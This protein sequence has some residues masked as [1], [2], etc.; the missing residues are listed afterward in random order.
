MWPE[1]SS[2]SPRSQARISC[3][4]AITMMASF[5]PAHAAGM[6]GFTT[7]KVIQFGIGYCPSLRCDK[8]APFLCNNGQYPMASSGCS[9][10]VIRQYLEDQ[11]QTEL[12]HPRPAFAQPRVARGYVW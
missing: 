10:F 11:L 6:A 3:G 8:T 9:A 4:G 2:I 5:A 12:N 1:A 7:W